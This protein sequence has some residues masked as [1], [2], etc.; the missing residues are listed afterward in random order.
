MAFNM[1][2]SITNV[3]FDSMSATEYKT[4]FTSGI[5]FDHQTHLTSVSGYIYTSWSIGE[6]PYFSIR[7]LKP[8]FVIQVILPK[9]CRWSTSLAFPEQ[10]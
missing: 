7:M 1:Y 8:S 5:L 4:C 6:K 9:V 2:T 10:P 3:N